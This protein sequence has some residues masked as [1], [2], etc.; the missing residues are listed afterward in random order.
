MAWRF[1]PE[2]LEYE[3][4]G[5]LKCV[6]CGKKLKEEDIRFCAGAGRPPHCVACG[7]PV[8]HEVRLGGAMWPSLWKGGAYKDSNGNWWVI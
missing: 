6:R 3:D 8:M 2:V 5:N 1:D 7:V 4:H